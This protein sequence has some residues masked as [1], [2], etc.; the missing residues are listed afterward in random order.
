MSNLITQSRAL[1]NL[2]G[3]TPTEDELDVIDGLIAAA[4]E[5]IERHC[6][7][8]FSVTT[9][10]ELHDGQTDDALLLRAYPVQSVTRVAYGPAAA[11]RVRNTSASV[12]QARA[13]VNSDSLVLTRVAS[14]VPTQNTLLFSA[15]VTLSALQSAISVVG[16]GWSADVIHADDANLASAD[17]GVFPGAFAARERDAE[18]KL[19]RQELGD[20]FVNAPCGVLRPIETQRGWPGGRKFWRVVYTAGYTSVPEDAQEACGQLVAQ[21]FWQTKRDPGLAQESVLSAISRRPHDGWSPLI[22][23]LLR[24]YRRMTRL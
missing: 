18:L 9:F 4:S 23:D 12:Q 1:R 5:A 20:Y 17:L 7:R 2:V 11:L 22:Y 21:L 15:H 3:V 16:N 24:P 8:A 14:G 10:D 19:H 13:Q 6:A